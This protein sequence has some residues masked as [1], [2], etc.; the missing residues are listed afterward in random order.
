ML[1]ADS[2]CTPVSV[3]LIRC[4]LGYCGGRSP[5]ISLFS[6]HRLIFVFFYV[7]EYWWH[8]CKGGVRDPVT[9][10]G[11]IGR[12]LDVGWQECKQVYVRYLSCCDKITNLAAIRKVSYLSK[13]GMGIFLLN[14][15]N[16]FSNNSEKLLKSLR[17]YECL[18]ARVYNNKVCFLCPLISVL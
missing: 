7:V 12:G 6:L 5:C 18:H 9:R 11:L 15:P 3:G 13:I 10:C 16:S 8:G 14:C 1:F 17:V 4:D 2:P